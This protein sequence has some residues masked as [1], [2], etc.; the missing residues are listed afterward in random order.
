MNIRKVLGLLLGVC[1]FQMAFAAPVQPQRM[2]KLAESAFR[3]KQAFLGRDVYIT[4]RDHRFVVKNGDTLLLIMNFNKGF[5]VMSTDDAVAPVLA[6]STDQNLEED[7][8][9]P[10]ARQWLDSYS[11]AVLSAK[12]MSL[13]QSPKV[14]QQWA[15]LTMQSAPKEDA[16]PVVEPLLTALWNQTKYYNAYSPEDADAPTGY[17]GRTPNGCVA[18]AMAM[19]MY[20]YRYPLHG[21]GSHTNYTEYGDFYVDFS[22]QTYFYEAMKDQLDYYN[23][24]VAKLI[25]HCAT[26]V[27]MWYGADGSGASSESVPDALTSYFG[28]P[29]GMECIRR[30][31][32]TLPQWKDILKTELNAHRPVY[33]SGCSDEG[34]HAFVCDGYDSED[35]FHFNFGWGGSSNGFYTLTATENDSVVVGGYNHSQRMVRS[36]APPDEVYPHYCSEKAIVCESGT[37]EDGSG[38]SNY[39]NNSDC[40]YYIT[41]DCAYRFQIVVKS[42]DTEENYDSLSF[43]DGH[44][45]QGSLLQ[46]LSG[47]LSS[48]QIYYFNTDTLYITFKTNSSVTAA[49]WRLDYRVVRCHTSCGIAGLITDY[50]GTISDGSGESHYKSNACCYWHLYLPMA[51]Y[52]TIDFPLI[53]IAEGDVLKIFD[54]SISPKVE[55]ASFSGLNVPQQTF[56]TNKIIAEFVSDNYLNGDGFELHWTSDYSPEGIDDLSVEDLYLF[57]NP[58]ATTVDVSLPETMRDAEILL[59]DV[60]GRL[61]RKCP[62]AGDTQVNVDVSLLPNGFYV[63][64]IQNDNYSVKKKMI[65]QH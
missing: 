51:S 64:V 3:Q 33:Y 11:D 29:S 6:Y 18:V 2:L 40:T 52:I 37:L 43:W 19:I 62:N 24:E 45:S 49:G 61:V 31:D 57:P 20:Y 25:F 27:D 54:A 44:P 9:P 36:I 46:T 59:Y 30:H 63:V 28:Y 21:Y 58:A 1:L 60:S 38:P 53:D 17:D 47:T 55:L 34:C 14:A 32:Y 13:P 39:L 4:T 35:Y 7:N 65:V 42:F 10:A 50:R 22:Q 41:E 8:V 5:I 16:E 56:Y 26:A 15:A 23:N 48:E 12:R